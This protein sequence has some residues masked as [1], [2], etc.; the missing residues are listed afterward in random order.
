M[1]LGHAQN[2]NPVVFYDPVV[3]E[4]PISQRIR[5]RLRKYFRVAKE[6]IHI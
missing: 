6:Y 3:F 1:A 2:Y 4:K 5:R